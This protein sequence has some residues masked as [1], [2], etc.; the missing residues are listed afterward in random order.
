MMTTKHS[1][2][3]L[4]VKEQHPRAASKSIEAPET[5]VEPAA[6]CPLVGIG[7]SAVGLDAIEPFFSGMAGD[8]NPG[9]PFTLVQQS[10][11]IR[12]SEAERCRV[13]F[14]QS[15]DG[16]VILDRNGKVCDANHRFAEMLGYTPDELLHL[17][18]WDWDTQWTQAQLLDM[19]QSVDD[20]GVLIETRHRR[21][22]GSMYDVEL[23]SNAARIDGKDF[24]FCVCRDVTNRAMQDKQAKLSMQVLATLNREN[25]VALLVKD[26][27]VLI[28]DNCGFEA[29]GIRLRDGDDFPYCETN[30]FPGHFVAAERHLCARAATGELIRDTD[31]NPLLECMCGNIVCGNFDPTKPFFTDNGS[32]WTNSTTALLA[33]TTEADRQSR[34]RNC[35]NG[36]GYES[37]AL[38]P[39]RGADETIGL[40][41]INDHRKGMFTPTMIQYFEG[42]GASIGIAVKRRRLAEAVNNSEQRFHSLFGNMMNGFAYCRMLYDGD[43]PADFVYLEV[44]RAFETLTGLKDVVGKRVSEVIPGIL[45]TNEVLFQLYARVARTGVAE[46][47]EYYVKEL[48]LWFALAIYSAEKDHFAAVFDVINARKQAEQRDHMAHEVVERL[49]HAG[50]LPEMVRDVL[51]TIQRHTGFD[52]VGLRLREG[53]VFPWYFQTG[54]TQEFLSTENTMVVWDKDDGLCRNRDGSLCLECACGLVLSGKT[55]SSTLLFTPGGSFWTNDALPLPYLPA[56]KD[57]RLH[58]RNRCLLDGFLSVALIPLRVG[59]EIIGV[60]QLHDHRSQQLNL[61][62][63]KF[64]EDRATSIATTI[65]RK[66]AEESLLKSECEFRTLAESM[67]QIVWI[68][69]ADGWNIYF[70][71]QWIDYTGLTL[72]QSYGH[73]WIAPFH[74]DDRQRAWDAWQRAT[75]DNDTYSVECRLRRVDGAIR[76]WLIRGVPLRNAGGKIM[77]W[78]GTCTDIE[79]I[80]QATIDLQTLTSRQEAILGA[81]PDIIVEVDSRKVYVWSNAAGVAFFGKDVIGKEAAFY[82]EG[83]ENV[84]RTVQPLFDGNQDV[85]QVENWQRRQD[86]EKRLLAWRCRVLKDTHGNV[87]GA[88]SSANDITDIRRTE[89][90]LRKGDAEF[91]AMFEV[92]SIGM[93][94]ADPL[95]GHWVR[96][97]HKMCEITGYSVQELLQKNIEEITHPE[98]RQKDWELFQQVVRGEVPDYRLEKRYLRKDG[99]VSWVNVYMTVVRDTAGQPVRTMATIEDITARKQA[100]TAHG[101]MQNQLM[102]AQKNGICGAA[103]GRGRARLQ[104]SAHG[105]NGLRRS[106]PG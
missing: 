102:Q 95:T 2:S 42:L 19:V 15:R 1:K 59:D 47:V 50:T 6:S 52:H 97:N 25:D 23:N 81:I 105:H 93:A 17:H 3:K 85:L 88:L 68:T 55:E 103:R 45:E 60:L 100:E 69:R 67:P 54:F 101:E 27:L 87:T 82:F 92:A 36:E 8:G 35:C 18:V 66:T 77:K 86:G 56:E 57:P 94:Q 5:A 91:R 99:R 4:I 10:K 49:N 76:W 7:V 72:E 96:V 79:E 65:K 53:D 62:L 75:H 74:P 38:I 73:G 83:E 28:K 33:S 29:V 51:Q 90:E 46:H 80:K 78:F 24:I 84:Y 63:V 70:N 21:K 44:N 37:V 41:Q 106:L 98:D 58:P 12:M 16:I 26:L 43:Q 30:G 9:M 89:D 104:Q 11:A 40:L 32:F 13:L 20:E 61:E 71:Q 34:T 31:G 22:D 39:L 48:N 64:L 14:E